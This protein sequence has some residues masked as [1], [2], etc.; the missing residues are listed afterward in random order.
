MGATERRLLADCDH[1]PAHDEVPVD[2]LVTMVRP[3]RLR[4]FD[5]STGA[6]PVGVVT[7]TR[8]AALARFVWGL[9]IGCRTRRTGPLRSDGDERPTDALRT[10]PRLLGLVGMGW[11]A[12]MPNIQIMHNDPVGGDE[13][14]FGVGLL[15]V[16]TTDRARS[17]SCA[18]SP[19]SLTGRSATR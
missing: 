4:Y 12:A 15:P 11:D 9:A 7:R 19:N 6:C 3:P 17:T 13:D 2:V 18:F 10:Q 14:R 16:L 1:Q 8:R 5:Q